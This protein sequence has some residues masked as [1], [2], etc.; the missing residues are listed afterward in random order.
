MS[1]CGTNMCPICDDTVS[2]T[3]CVGVIGCAQPSQHNGATTI[4]VNTDPVWRTGNINYIPEL[5]KTDT[6]N[7]CGSQGQL[8]ILDQSGYCIDD[9]IGKNPQIMQTSPLN[10]GSEELNSFTPDQAGKFPLQ[11]LHKVWG[12]GGSAKY[13]RGVNARNVYLGGDLETVSYTLGGSPVEFRQKVLYMEV[14]GD[15]YAGIIPGVMKDA[16]MPKKDAMCLQPSGSLTTGDGKVCSTGIALPQC[17]NW[18]EISSATPDYNKRVGGCACTRETFGPG[19]YNLLCY[20]PKTGDQELDGRGYV[21]AMWP[22]HY[23]EVYAKNKEGVTPPTSQYRSET[24][25]PCYNECET[26]TDTGPGAAKNPACPTDGCKDGGDLFSAI[27]HEI[28]IEIP[29]NSPQWT[30]TFDDWKKNATWGSMNCNTWVNDIYNYDY[31]TGA[32]YTQVGVKKSGSETYIS[33]VPETEPNKDY[34]WYTL[35]WSVG[36]AGQDDYVAFYYDDPFD[37]LGKSQINGS[38]L[39]VKPA[40]T[41]LVHKTTRFVPTRP[42]RL[43]FG[44]WMA[45]WGYGG[46][47]GGVPNFDSAKVRMAYLGISPSGTGYDFPQSYDQLGTICD[48]ADLYSK[49][50]SPSPGPGPSHRTT[51][52]KPIIWIMISCIILIFIAIWF[53]MKRR[54]IRF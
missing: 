41:G 28:D 1:D 27:N 44:P 54:K 13:N 18:V 26:E 32:Y 33:S 19:V 53:Y 5:R 23:E 25:Y 50:S 30:K 48:F 38:A 45:W 34:H 7:T 6:T 17:P 52:W 29:S 12:D 40:G 8:G 42:G 2:N 3:P 16:H 20:I 15:K 39:P 11:A 43:N 24:T 51:S 31:N 21:F 22:F 49:G 47:S 10:I 46:A 14:H 37:P 36:V 35:D 9:T 4:P